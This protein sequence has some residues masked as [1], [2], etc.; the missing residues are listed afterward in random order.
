MAPRRRMMI[1]LTAL[2]DLLFIIMFLQ[3]MELQDAS[4]QQVAAEA[5]RRQLAETARL[6]AT[7]LKES[8]LANTED[9]NRRLQLLESENKSLQEKLTEANKRAAVAQVEQQAEEKRAAA[10]MRAIASAVKD[11][12]N[13]PADALVGAIGPAPRGEREK[14]RQ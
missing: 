8:A 7:R 11:M 4:A 3:Y 9:M 1:Q 6:D 13:I 5:S 2:V 14:L 12:M 10:D